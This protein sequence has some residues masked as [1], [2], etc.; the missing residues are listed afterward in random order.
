M[1]EKLKI[2]ESLVEKHISSLKE[3]YLFSNID[4]YLIKSYQERSV[5]LF[6]SFFSHKT[7]TDLVK[8]TEYE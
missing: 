6:F 7:G 2:L 4:D 8:T 5:P 3:N 1:F